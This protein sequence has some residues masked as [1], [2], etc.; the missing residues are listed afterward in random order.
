VIAKT[1][2]V[3]LSAWTADPTLTKAY[4]PHFFNCVPNSEQQAE[5]ILADLIK[6]RGLSEWILI[7]DPSYDNQKAVEGISSRETYGQNPPL[8]HFTCRS[9]QDLESIQ[10]EILGLR[11]E[12]VVIFCEPLL[13]W[14]LIR[15]LRSQ[16]AEMP[17]YGSPALLDKKAL[18]EVEQDE[19]QKVYVPGTSHKG[20]QGTGAEYVYDAIHLLAEAIVKSGFDRDQLMKAVLNT[21]HKGKTGTIEFDS[22]GNRKGTPGLVELDGKNFYGRKP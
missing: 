4:V 16:S 8:N 19:L 2:I 17:V 5:A 21:E 7:S 20:F 10:K 15:M 14:R 12:A 6:R 18:D 11:A 22:L 13:A 3:F 1:S 9:A